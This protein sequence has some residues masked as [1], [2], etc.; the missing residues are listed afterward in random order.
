MN[1]K[2]YS[3]LDKQD[4]DRFD[5]ALEMLDE[6]INELQDISSYMVPESIIRYGLRVSLENFCNNIPGVYFQYFGSDRRLAD[7]LEVILYR[8]TC[9]LVDNI[10]KYSNS[11]NINVQLIIDEGITSLTVHGDKRKIEKTKIENSLKNIRERLSGYNG[12]VNFHSF[13]E[14]GTEINIEIESV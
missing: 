6:S 3:I 11:Q 13:D 12:K 7:H 4:I 2:K 1:M 9:E 10:L 8:C 14:E 5:K